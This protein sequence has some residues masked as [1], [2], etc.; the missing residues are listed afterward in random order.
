[1]HTGKTAYMQNLYVVAF[2]FLAL[3]DTCCTDFVTAFP[4]NTSYSHTRNK[5]IAF[6]GHLQIITE[7]TDKRR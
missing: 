5:Y 3:N 4:I 6:W 7:E 1:M 2:F